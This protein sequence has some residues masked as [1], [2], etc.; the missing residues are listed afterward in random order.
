MQIWFKS[1][2]HVKNEQMDTQHQN[3]EAG[4]SEHI[5]SGRLVVIYRQMA[6]YITDSL[7]GF[8]LLSPLN[9]TICILFAIL[10]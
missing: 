8:G 2:S 7:S 3:K 9:T 5:A 10:L 6:Q 4:M 1:L